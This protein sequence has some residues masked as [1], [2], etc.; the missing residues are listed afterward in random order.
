MGLGE[1]VK[2]ILINSRPDT[3][4]SIEDAS[5]DPHM[6]DDDFVNSAISEKFNFVFT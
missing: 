4:A 3:C 1:V 5:L 6:I 2:V